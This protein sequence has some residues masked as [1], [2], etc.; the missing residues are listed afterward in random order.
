MALNINK[1]I[2]V[3]TPSF[4]PRAFK[5]AYD[6]YK[7]GRLTN[8][9][10]MFEYAEIDSHITGCLLGRDAGY[11]KDWQIKAATESSQDEAIKEFIEQYF[12]TL[13]ARDLFEDIIEAKYKKFTVLE[14]ADWEIMDNKQVPTELRKVH[15]KYF[16]FDQNDENKL[17]IDHVTE[18]LEDIPE[19]SALIINYRKNPIFLPVLRDYILK[20]FG[21][22]SW[23]AFMETFGEPFIIGKYPP[24]SD[25]SFINQVEEA[26]NAI[27][28]SSRGTAPI[29]SEF[30]IKETNRNTG[31]HKTFVERC[32]AGISITILGHENAVKESPGLKIGENLSAYKVK[33]EIA[34]DDIHFIQTHLNQFIKFLV[35]RNYPAVTKFPTFS[36]DKSEPINVKER[37]LILEQAFEQGVELEAAEY[38]LLG[39]KV[40]E[41]APNL[42]KPN[43]L[44]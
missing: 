11:K 13:N 29:G 42:S 40:Q 6:N 9:V 23:A 37:L 1:K 39:I 15:Q 38:A 2:G 27:G 24:N 30:E 33:R 18:R 17:K 28:S 7:L 19:N 12:I 3:I 43:L 32:D 44:D 26:V 36:I 16:R 21:V 25:A 22:E 10:A 5:A 20:E 31:D 4:T 8:L 35:R 41:N 34:L 14:Y